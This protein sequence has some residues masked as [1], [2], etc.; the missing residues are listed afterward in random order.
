MFLYIRQEAGWMTDTND[1]RHSGIAQ[2]LDKIIDSNVRRRTRQDL[3][4]NQ[5][6]CSC[7]MVKIT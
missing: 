2:F 5:I 4:T 7:N 3:D 6:N 1:L